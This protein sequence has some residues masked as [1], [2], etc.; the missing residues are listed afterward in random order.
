MNKKILIGSIIAVVIL[1]LV[2]FT[3]VVGY[4]TTKSS[5]IARASPL[6][7][8]R[9]KRAID[10]ESRDLTCDYI[11]KG[12]ESVLS[13]P[14]RN[15]RIE[16]V[17]KVIDIISKMDDNNFK[18]FTDSI[19]NRL[20]QN[21]RIDDNDISSL[22]V[23]LQQLKNN[24]ETITKELIDITDKSLTE[25]YWCTSLEGKWYPGCMVWNVFVY[26]FVVILFIL[27]I[28]SLPPTSLLICSSETLMIC[29]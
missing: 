20:H 5:T 10:E 24:P 25:H 21:N 12:E 18:R 11:G 1:V 3:G 27:L 26:T 4:Q 14:K 8:V 22:I 29:K 23:A 9:S 28:I 16:M 17:Q 2:S 15:G 19:I 6:F 13:I 7:S